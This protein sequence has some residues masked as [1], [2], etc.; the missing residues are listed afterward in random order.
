MPTPELRPHPAPRV[1]R[2][3]LSVLVVLLALMVS[4][5]P[6]A[7][8]RRDAIRERMNHELAFTRAVLLSTQLGFT[9]AAVESRGFL[10]TRDP[11]YLKA[12]RRSLSEGR[13]SYARLDDLAANLDPSLAGPVRELQV[14]S[15][16]WFDPRSETVS[17]RTLTNPDSL[18]NRVARGET[19]LTGIRAA[20]SGVDLALVQ[21]EARM[22]EEIVAWERAENLIVAGL[23]LAGLAIA[24]L[25]GWLVRRL[26]QASRR[27]A[28]S[29][30]RFR[31]IADNVHEAIWIADPAYSTYHY[32]NP[33]QE[34]LWGSST[35]TTLQDARSFLSQVHPEDRARVET[36]LESFATAISLHNADYT[37]SEGNGRGSAGVVVGDRCPPA[38]S[39]ARRRRTAQESGVGGVNPTSVSRRITYSAGGQAR[40]AGE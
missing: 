27:L 39:R 34:R 20:A 25:F 32:I 11:T 16:L 12:M 8:G 33:A 21:I 9:S 22:N 31:Q 1:P 36:A 15:T 30:E 29:E 40:M 4:V 26:A 19:M 18:E 5:P 6:W 3:P 23:G 28:E 35:A 13:S 10:V 17:G 37:N 7:G 24:L 38:R 2:W 14:A